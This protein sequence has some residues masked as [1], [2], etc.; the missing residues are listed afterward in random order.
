MAFYLRLLLTEVS[1]RRTLLISQLKEQARTYPPLHAF[2][3]F[4]ARALLS[5]VPVYRYAM[6]LVCVSVS[7]TSRCS[8]K[9]A[10]RICK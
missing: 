8:T 5:A 9:T 2:Q 6:A 1:S 10:K 3:C 4:T 7:V